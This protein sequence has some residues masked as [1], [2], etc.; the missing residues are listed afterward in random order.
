L[1]LDEAALA[2][3]EAYLKREVF[4]GRLIELRRDKITARNRFSSRVA[5]ASAN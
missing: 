5:A 3:E 4:G 2:E 1:L